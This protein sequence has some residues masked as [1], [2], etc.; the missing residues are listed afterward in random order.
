MRDELEG[1]GFR[2]PLPGSLHK[3]LATLC[4]CVACSWVALGRVVMAGSACAEGEWIPPFVS[5]RGGRCRLEG[6]A[7]G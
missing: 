1:C 3:G 7:E 4:K 5:K 2:W 6:C